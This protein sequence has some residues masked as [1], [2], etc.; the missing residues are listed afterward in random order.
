MRCL[1]H[2]FLRGAIALSLLALGGTGAM[3]MPQA[4]PPACKAGAGNA[5]IAA[6]LVSIDVLPA[7]RAPLARLARGERPVC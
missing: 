5:P 3:L 2:V 4:A 7:S 6:P 1:D